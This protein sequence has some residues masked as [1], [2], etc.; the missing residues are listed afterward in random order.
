M[1]V[2]RITAD[3]KN[4]KNIQTLMENFD[5]GLSEGDQ[6]DEYDIVVATDAISEGYNLHRAGSIYNY[7]IPYNP[8]IIIQRVGRINRINKRVFGELD[9]FNFFPSLI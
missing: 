5:A 8:T 3:N 6:K 1:R 4:K 2:L 9:I 7:D